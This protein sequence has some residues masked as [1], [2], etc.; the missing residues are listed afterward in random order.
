MSIDRAQRVSDLYHRALQRTPEERGAFL[1]GGVQE[2]DGLRQE[3]ESLLEYESPSA[4]F[5]EHPAAGVAADA[6]SSPR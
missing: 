3:V 2:D 4:R 1:A 5:L 6:P